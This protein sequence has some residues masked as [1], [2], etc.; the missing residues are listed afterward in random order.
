M[1]ATWTKARHTAVR[2]L[3][4]MRGMELYFL[5]KETFSPKKRHNFAFFCSNGFFFF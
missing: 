3:R 1:S 5:C 4:K 2:I